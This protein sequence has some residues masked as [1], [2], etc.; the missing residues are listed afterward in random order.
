MAETVR[1]TAIEME[2]VSGMTA[3]DAP[4]P[5]GKRKREISPCG[6]A[7]LEEKR[8]LRAYGRVMGSRYECFVAGWIAGTKWADA[9]RPKRR[10]R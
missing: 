4:A 1:D 8:R 3:P 10:M 5:R 2:R 6:E 9:G 7:W